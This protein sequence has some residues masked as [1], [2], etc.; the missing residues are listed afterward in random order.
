MTK[1]WKEKVKEMGL[2]VDR[3]AQ[4]NVMNDEED[5][6]FENEADIVVKNQ[7]DKLNKAA[8]MVNDAIGYG[9]S[10]QSELA[11]INDKLKGVKTKVKC[12]HTR[13]Y[14]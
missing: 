4:K 10:T 14:L 9:T 1:D 3:F 8:R 2:Q 7:K 5:G 11:R 13:L 12:D 6:I